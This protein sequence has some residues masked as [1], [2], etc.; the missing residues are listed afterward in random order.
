MECSPHLRGL[1]G[2]REMI[3]LEYR[4]QSEEH[5]GAGDQGDYYCKFWDSGSVSSWDG[6]VWTRDGGFLAP[7]GVGLGYSCFLTESAGGRPPVIWRQGAEIQGQE[8]EAGISVTAF[9]HPFPNC[10]Y[11]EARK[12]PFPDSFAARALAKMERFQQIFV[13]SLTMTPGEGVHRTFSWTR[14]LSN[15]LVR[16]TSEF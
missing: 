8:V 2:L 6:G 4:A 13:W 12:E 9:C 15:T 11:W 3:Y 5:S 16:G 10:R 14:A 1:G 7:I